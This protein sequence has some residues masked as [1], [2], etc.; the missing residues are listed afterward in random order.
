M[1]EE[2]NSKYSNKTLSNT[3]GSDQMNVSSMRGSVITNNFSTLSNT[4]GESGFNPHQTEK[5]GRKNLKRHLEENILLTDILKPRR[6]SQS[7]F[8]TTNSTNPKD[9]EEQKVNLNNNTKEQ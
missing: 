5:S 9:L 3:E 2:V 8:R 4:L 7:K 6:S 1:S